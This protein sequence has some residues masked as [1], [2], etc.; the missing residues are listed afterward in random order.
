M[1]IT[2][3]AHFA[4][5]PKIKIHRSAFDRSFDHKTTWNNGDLVP[6]YWS[7][8]LPGDT[9]SMDVSSVVRMSTPIKPIMDNV[10]FDMYW[11]FVPNRLIDA[12]WEK[13]MGALPPNS[14]WTSPTEYTV[15]QISFS[16][17]YL[18]YWYKE[19][20]MD[21]TT[22]SN[23]ITHAFTDGD[24]IGM[25]LY[26]KNGSSY[27]AV[28]STDTYSSSSHYY[29]K[30]NGYGPGSLAS[31]MGLPIGCI[32]YDSNGVTETFS[33]YPFRAYGLIWNEFFCDRNYMNPVDIHYNDST[34][35][36]TKDYRY[37]DITGNPYPSN[38]NYNYVNDT[39]RGAKCLRVSRFH[40][41]FSSSLPQPQRGDPVEIPIGGSAPVIQTETNL[42][43]NTRGTTNIHTL[44]FPSGVSGNTQPQFNVGGTTLASPIALDYNSGLSADLSNI[45]SPATINDLRMAFQTQKFLEQSARGG[46]RYIEIINSFF[47]VSN[48]DYRL[49]RPEYLGGSRSYLNVT[50][51][52]QTSS[53]DSTSPQGNTAAYSLTT[54]KG[55][56]FTKSFTEHGIL[57]CV[58]CCRT[59]RSYQQGF[60]KQFKR[61]RKFDFYFP[62]FAHLGEQ[63]VN[64]TEL[65]CLN[66]QLNSSALAYQSGVLG[67]QERYAEYKY[68]PDLVSGD[69]ASNNEAPLDF[70]HFADN[71]AWNK[72]AY[73]SQEWLLEGPENLDRCLA[74]TSSQAHQFVGD[75]YFKAKYVRPM[76]LYCVPGLADHF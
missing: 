2:S 42:L 52:L 20:D 9:V 21:S 65:Y 18:P 55:S 61:K 15:P 19:V 35:T 10:I 60:N 22:F 5:S 26:V 17:S 59:S 33:Q 63:E 75:F 36:Y 53:T 46:T 49:Q 50:Q 69:F 40:D 45:V 34:N 28:V 58:G 24:F 30:F 11:F 70:W 56:A 62:V 48:P 39:V 54:D 13:V 6:F 16:Q 74:V 73:I 4:H 71:Y 66:Q 14:H 51:V 37:G 29:V 23:Y 32:P 31:Y 44:H 43:F 8:I 3:N 41:Y 7:E 64:A 38:W 67:Y 27:D 47:G 12:N 57:M 68:H 25:T 72:P 1:S 76:P